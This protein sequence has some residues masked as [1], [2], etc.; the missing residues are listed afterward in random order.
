[1]H[2]RHLQEELIYS[3]VHDHAGDASCMEPFTLEGS[4]EEISTFVGK[5]RAT[6][7]TLTVDRSVR[8]V[9]GSDGAP[10]G[11]SPSRA[12]VEQVRQR[13]VSRARTD[14]PTGFSIGLQLFN[15]HVVIRNQY[16]CTMF[17]NG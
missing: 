2:L 17:V 7:D 8:P 15:L 10:T 9:D 6:V 16:P 11:Y 14:D 12:D 5:I 13:P 4:L 3:N 1:M